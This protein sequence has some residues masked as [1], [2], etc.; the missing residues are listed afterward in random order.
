MTSL[1]NSLVML[2][3]ESEEVDMDILK[4]LGINALI[5]AIVGGAFD[6]A[7]WILNRKKSNESIKRGS[8]QLMSSPEE[9]RNCKNLY[10]NFDEE[11]LIDGDTQDVL[12]DFSQCHEPKLEMTR[13]F[14]NNLNQ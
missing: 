12:I 1:M 4:K 10:F 8:I 11:V 7:L 5:G 13:M 3:K 6:L 14:W 2:R 9:I